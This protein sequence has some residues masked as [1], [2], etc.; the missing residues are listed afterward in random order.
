MKVS[1]FSNSF[2]ITTP[3]NQYLQAASTLIFPFGNGPVTIN[4]EVGWAF[5]F[6]H[7]DNMKMFQQ[8]YYHHSLQSMSI[9][10]I[11]INL[12]V[13]WSGTPQKPSVA[14]ALSCG[15]ARGETQQRWAVIQKVVASNI[16]E[17]D[18]LMISHFFSCLTQRSTPLALPPY[19]AKADL[20]PFI[21]QLTLL[22]Y[23]AQKK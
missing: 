13:W 4:S 3:S 11:Y 18:L 14:A 20:C 2:I 8:L 16:F 21:T 6:W 5:L 10:C 17:F 23:S 19:S 1:K 9:G 7:Y 12:S 22:P 15:L